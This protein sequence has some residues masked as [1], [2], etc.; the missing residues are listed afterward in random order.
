MRF[1]NWLKFFVV[2][3]LILVGS[4]SLA[5]RR[6]PGTGTVRLPSPPETP[7]TVVV[8][9]TVAPAPEEVTPPSAEPKEA[10]PA[11][12]MVYLNVLS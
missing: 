6:A 10:A 11:E 7:E 12:E 4:T 3:S 9:E 1:D 8:D 5:Q 2:L